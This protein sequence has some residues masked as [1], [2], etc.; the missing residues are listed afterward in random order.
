MQWDFDAATRE[1]QLTDDNRTLIG[2]DPPASAKTDSGY[3]I[4]LSGS[5]TG[6]VIALLDDVRFGRGAHA[7]FRLDD[8][9]V[10]RIHFA[11]E[12]RSDGTFA[13][14]DL[15][16]RNGTFVNGSRVQVALLHDGDTVRV[17]T[18]AVMKFASAAALD[19][20][21]GEMYE[22]AVCDGLTGLYS[23]RYLF[24]QLRHEYKFAR[25]HAMPVSVIVIGIDG[26]RVTNDRYGIVV[27]DAVIKAV[28]R[29]V[30]ACIRDEDVLARS[31]G[32]QFAIVCRATSQ[33]GATLLAAR[34]RTAVHDAIAIDTMPEVQVTVSSGIA[35]LPELTMTDDRALFDAAEA[36]MVEA[37]RNGRNNIHINHG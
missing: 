24:D 6:S 20:V 14:E 13:L 8:E 21:Q 7:D 23:R 30:A 15:R 2:S 1:L 37:K 16:S 5:R 31:G 22:A 12:P 4:V 27:G 33:G 25:R 9:G 35:S 19:A 3:L 10:S 17:G 34:L 28:S 26:M 36:A 18:G 11:I 29:A 32:D